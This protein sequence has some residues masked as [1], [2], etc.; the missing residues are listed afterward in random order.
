M[1]IEIPIIEGGFGENCRCITDKMIAEIHKMETYNVR[2][3]ITDNLKRFHEN[4]DYIDLS[5]RLCDIKTLDLVKALKYSKQAIKQAGHIYI[6]SERG[7]A[8][9][10]KIMDTDLAWEIHDRLMDEYFEMRKLIKEEL[11]LND[12][13]LLK[14]C[15]ATTD[16]E[17]ALAVAE[18]N[19]K[20]VNPLKE[21]IEKQKPMVGLAELRIDKKGCYSLTDVNKSLGLKRG[22]ITNW[23]KERGYIHKTLNEVNADGEKLFKVYSSDGL[24]NQIGITND[25]LQF[26][27][28]NIDEISL[29]SSKKEG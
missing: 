22:R 12:L 18:Y 6:L 1:G 9:L 16:S 2:A 19:E 14:I 10:I 28:Q 3:R 11:S 24:H 26:I 5:Q 17:K 23:A 15:K 29:C 4:V 25:G 27:K 13:L 8:K 7:Y 20:I 21:T